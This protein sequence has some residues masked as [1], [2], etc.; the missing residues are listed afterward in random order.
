MHCQ[1]IYITFNPTCVRHQY[2]INVEQKIQN[3]NAVSHNLNVQYTNQ[4][5]VFFNIT[6]MNAK[7]NQ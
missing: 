4:N 7:I 5:N 6:I 3:S 1:G 2:K